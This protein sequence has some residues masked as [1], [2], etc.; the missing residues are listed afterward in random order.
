M[1]MGVSG[2]VVDAETHAALSGSS[3]SFSVRGPTKPPIAISEADGSFNLPK[4][5][6]WQLRFVAGDYFVNP[7]IGGTVSIRHDGY[8]TNILEISPYDMYDRFYT[9]ISV[10]IIPLKPLPKTH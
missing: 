9:K 5:K 8:E 7:S 3:V 2:T 10:G 1:R 4:Q 6:Q